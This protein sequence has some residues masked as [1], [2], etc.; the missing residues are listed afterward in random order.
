MSRLFVC[1]ILILLCLGC[2]RYATVQSFQPKRT[3]PTQQFWSSSRSLPV[4]CLSS[5]LDA[6]AKGFGGSDEGTATK[7]GGKKKN[8]KKGGGGGGGGGFG[9]TGSGTSSSSSSSSPSPLP[10]KESIK[11]QLQNKYGGTTPEEIARGTQRLIDQQISGLPPELQQALNYHRQ[12]LEWERRWSSMDLLAQANVPF[13]QV[14]QMDRLKEELDNILKEASSK[15]SI[16][17]TSRDD[18]Q[19]LMQQITWN[20]SA[21]AK[22][23]KSMT[24]RM[25]KDI[26]HRVERASQ[27]AAEAL[28]Q[29]PSSSMSKND[30][31][32]LDVGCGYGV[33]TPYLQ[34]AGIDPSRI[35][36]ID[37]SPDMI[38]NAHNIHGSKGVR[39][40]VM[41]FMEMSVS[42]ETRNENENGV[43]PTSCGPYACVVFCASLHDMPDIKH[44]LQ[45]ARDLLVESSVSAS[46]S[47]PELPKGRL[48]I[49]H[50]QGASHVLQQHKANPVLVPRALPTA[51]E[52]KDW[53]CVEDPASGTP[54]SAVMEL[55][56]PPA[57]PKSKEEIREG[58]IAV[59]DFR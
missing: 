12:L 32:V 25:P 56:H 10:S 7:K 39:F 58:Y 18:L 30:A 49:V 2:R 55:H 31:R 27:Y 15:Y 11:K 46:G 16:S 24:G 50:P 26:E 51:Q 21:D 47:T 45:K 13:T 48:V 29:S 54:V 57:E 14:E 22:A 5:S 38:R 1:W 41:N 40:D 37:L 52:L 35:H 34:K 44:A 20:A 43:L 33:M 59:L 6:T 23:M 53:L 36:G 19:V 42:T 17:M 9:G 28:V 8:S 4:S 3:T